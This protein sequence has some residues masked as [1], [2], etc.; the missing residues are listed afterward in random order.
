VFKTLGKEVV[1]G[2]VS[3]LSLLIKNSFLIIHIL[4]ILLTTTILVAKS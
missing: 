4:L 3:F 2:S 1:F